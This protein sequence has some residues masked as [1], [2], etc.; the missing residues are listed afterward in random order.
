MHLDRKQRAKHVYVA[1]FVFSSDFPTTADA[2]QPTYIGG[3]AGWDQPAGDG[4]VSKILMK[5]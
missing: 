3:T 2:F 5:E 4:F 1:G